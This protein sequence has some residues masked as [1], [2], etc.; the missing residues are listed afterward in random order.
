M[1]TYNV[2]LTSQITGK[3]T[4]FY[5][6]VSLNTVQLIIEANDSM[7]MADEICDGESHELNCDLYIKVERS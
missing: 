7:M 2:T 3:V 4:K 5:E 1:K 6:D